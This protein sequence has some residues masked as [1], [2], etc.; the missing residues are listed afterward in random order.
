MNFFKK[1]KCVFISLCLFVCFCA[2][3]Y[4][5]TVNLNGD[6]S[7]SVKAKYTSGIVADVYSVDIEWGSMEFEYVDAGTKWDP[8]THTYKTE[9]EA[10]W[11]FDEGANEVKVTNHSNN[12]VAVALSYTPATDFS[13]I[14]GTFDVAEKTLASAEGSAVENAPSFTSKLTLGGVLFSGTTALTDVGTA[15]VTLS[16]VD[17]SN[18]M[19]ESTP[20]TTGNETEPKEDETVI[21]TDPVGYVYLKARIGEGKSSEY[22]TSIYQQSSNVYFADI[23]AETIIAAHFNPDTE[24]CINN[25]IYY[26]YEAGSGYQF[27]PGT[28][29]NINKNFYPDGDDT[30]KR[31]ETVIEAGKTYKLTITLDEASGTGTATLVLVG[32]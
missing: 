14:T 20:P 24:I 27:M 28:T 15:K 11:T 6:A 8:E 22:Q 3:A 30:A 7:V 13:G 31:K 25:K 1:L 26:I 5:A 23:C 2:P 12:P 21:P 18:S 32:A 4:A 10:K 9:T 29:V 16:A 17:S 19:L